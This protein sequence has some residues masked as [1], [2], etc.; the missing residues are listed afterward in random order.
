MRVERLA[1]SP[2]ILEP[3]ILMIDKLD[4]VPNG[5]RSPLRFDE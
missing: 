4:S 2:V 5:A 3:A 1:M